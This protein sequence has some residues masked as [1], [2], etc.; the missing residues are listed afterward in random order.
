MKKMM[1]FMAKTIEEQSV[2]LAKPGKAE[3]KRF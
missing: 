1:K 2:E 3:G